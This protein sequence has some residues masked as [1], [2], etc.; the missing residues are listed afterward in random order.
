MRSDRL[1]FALRENSLS[2][3][4]AGDILVLRPAGSDN[5]SA[6][7]KARLTV[8]QGMRPDYDAF[9]RLGYNVLP[10]L[11]QNHRFAA[12]LVCVPR[13]KAQARAL[14]A[15]A[16]S[17]VGPKGLIIVDGQKT[18]GIDSLLRDLRQRFTLSDT[19]AKAHGKL[20]TFQPGD[21]L[22][23]DWRAK[24]LQL[25]G[26]FQTLP[27]VFSADGPDAGSA[28]LASH[29]PEKLGNRIIDLGAGWGYLAHA[30]LQNAAVKEVHLVEA[31]ASAL[32]CA[33]AAI[34]DPRAQF[35]W[36]DATSFKLD[37]GVDTVICNPPFHTAR[38][39]DPALGEAFIR[40]AARLL[41]PHGTLWLVSNRHLP[42][43]RTIA[44]LFR[45]VEELGT[46]PRFRITRAARPHRAI[47]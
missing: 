13:A 9:A 11:P 4:D 16:A 41:A 22:M 31:E 36:A 23:V 15:D 27:G 35:H 30:A 39:P 28:L 37:R 40:A 12:A 25:D 18:D 8:V 26:G 17:A 24:P 10:D 3:P 6:L 38:D 45:E 19:V 43:A 21:D 42:Y 1:T 47:P 20:A 7:P 33:R 2:L 5:L 29:F 32:T 46:D 14:L 44:T 34:T